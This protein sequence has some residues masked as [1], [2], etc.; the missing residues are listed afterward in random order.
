MAQKEIYDYKEGKTFTFYLNRYE[1]ELISRAI[2]DRKKELE[3][4][5]GNKKNEEMIDHLD[6]IQEGLE[7]LL[8]VKEKLIEIVT[9]Q[10][11][12]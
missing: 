5:V 6:S 1:L 4:I 9:I 12:H 2:F 3:K 11:E 10:I 8:N 7:K